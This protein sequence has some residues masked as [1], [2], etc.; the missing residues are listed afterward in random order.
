MSSVLFAGVAAAG[1]ALLGVS[2]SLSLTRR[3]A[4]LTA[5]SRVL[6]K[7][8]AGLGYRA[9]TLEELL[10][11]AAEGETHRETRQALTACA[12]RMR[13][14][15]L[16]PLASAMAGIQLPELTCE[17]RAALSPLWQGL[18]AG[19]EEAQ[20]ALLRAVRAALA[21]QTEQAREKE[22]KDRRL[23]LSLGLIGGG[24]VFLFL[25]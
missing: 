14:E 13:E 24:V 20:R 8:E 22:Q 1:C 10:E 21:V 23:A 3:V 18:G 19:E 9:H 5:W 17:D 16:L 6:A 15:P 12:R 25:L 7:I 4:A 11:R 2:W